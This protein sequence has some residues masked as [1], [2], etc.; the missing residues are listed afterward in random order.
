M[1]PI[2]TWQGGDAVRNEIFMFFT[3][4]RL[5]YMNIYKKQIVKNC[6]L[7]F[8]LIS[9]DPLIE[10]CFEFAPLTPNT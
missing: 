5:Q 2:E 7:Q 10:L 9:I 6:Y 4:L 1:R 3:K 8:L